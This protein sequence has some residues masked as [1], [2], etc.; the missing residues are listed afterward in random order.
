MYIIYMYMYI[1]QYLSK[2]KSI[3]TSKHKNK[4][5]VCQYTRTIIIIITRKTTTTVIITIIALNVNNI[6]PLSFFYSAL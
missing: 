4:S 3:S 5:L 1:A 6:N 2:L